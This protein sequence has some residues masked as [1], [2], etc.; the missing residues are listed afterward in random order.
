MFDLGPYT[1]LRDQLAFVV[2]WA[3]RQGNPNLEGG[4]AGA[5][6]LQEHASGKS[7][8]PEVFQMRFTMTATEVPEPI[9][10]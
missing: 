8:S 3:M 2:Y 4:A 9:D 6:A 7:S 1:C 10:I 5:R